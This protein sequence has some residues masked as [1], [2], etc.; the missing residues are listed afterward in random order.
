MLST[1]VDLFIS[2]HLHS[3]FNVFFHS[4][5]L[6]SAY[7]YN[8]T[9]AIA[10]ATKKL[11]WNEHHIFDWRLKA[12]EDD[13]RAE[14]QLSTD[15]TKTVIRYCVYEFREINFVIA[16]RATS[17]WTRLRWRLARTRNSNASIFNTA[18]CR[19]ANIINYHFIL[20][21]MN[22]CSKPFVP[23]QSKVCTLNICTFKCKRYKSTDNNNKTKITAQN[24]MT[25]RVAAKINTQ[26]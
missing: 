18:A 1:W 5:S 4:L 22:V 14:I 17:K 16:L 19:L 20:R 25:Y 13:G 3:I 24:E 12:H 7:R 23:S 10:I 9:I 8:H 15:K 2:I 21:Y 11:A 6:S 26:R